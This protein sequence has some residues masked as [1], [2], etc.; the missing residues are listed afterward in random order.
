MNNI[1]FTHELIKGKIAEII[2]EQM[3]HNTKG[4]TVLEFGYEKVVH[5]LAKA[6]KSEDARAMIEIVRKAP[7][8]AI[9]NEDTHNVTLVEIKYM[10][11]R[12][13]GKVNAIAKEIE[14][15]WRHAALFIATPDG[16]FYDQVDTI[17]ANKGAVKPFH[18]GKIQPKIVDQYLAML[19]EFIVVKSS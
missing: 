17:I 11:K 10:A 9:V 15:S 2:F 18:H 14:K 12:T 16:F 7:D 6:P 8:Y 13:N 3:I 5:Q 4:Y 19:N 1:K